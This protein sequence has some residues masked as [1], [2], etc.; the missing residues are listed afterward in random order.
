MNRAN[1]RQGVVAMVVLVLGG[2]LPSAVRAQGEAQKRQAKEHY[3]KATRLYDVG[4]YGEA[5]AEYEQSYLLIGDAALLFN[6]GQAYRLWD[7]P[8]EAIRAYKNYLRQR[9][10]APNRADVERK[11]A[12]LEKTVEERKHGAGTPPP[13]TMPPAAVP[14]TAL[15]PTAPP[16]AAP[17][18][19]YYPPM[20][21]TTQPLPGPSVT[22]PG[23]P[24]GTEV[25]TQPAPTEEEPSSGG[26]WL[27]YSLLGV[28][29]AGFVTMTIA[30]VVGASK[31]KQ[32]RDASQNREV[33]DAAVESNGKAANA[34][35][36]VGGIVG[37]AA[38]GTAAY[39]L[40][41]QHSAAE[42]QVSFAPTLSPGFAGAAAS[43]TF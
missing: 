42:T 6:I 29:G 36:V 18:A 31:A 21:G 12:D 2:F 30:A 13:E 40:W 16:P 3:E 7:R 28:S 14:P 22:G 23:Q 17:P 1:A 35:A 20:P 26:Q 9:P 43:L 5:I 4:K 37:L 39:L 27:T 11:I 34:V 25:I 19:G 33:F 38:G 24:P 15:P 41:R 32:M 10:D 8:D